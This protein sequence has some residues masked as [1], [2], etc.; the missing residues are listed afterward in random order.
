MKKV[1]IISYFFPPANF[2][3]GDRVAAWFK[4][5]QTEGYYPIIVTRCWN[6]GQSDVIGKLEH[7]EYSVERIGNG[8]IHRIPLPRDLRNKMDGPIRKLLTLRRLLGRNT[9]APVNEFKTIYD[10]CVDLLKEDPEIKTVIA[11]GRPFESF[12]IGY[13]LKKE[14][15]ITWIPDYRDEWNTHLAPANESWIWRKIHKQERTFEKVWTSNADHFLSVSPAWVTRI[16]DF[17]QKEGTV[18]MNGYDQLIEQP[19]DKTT[20]HPAL[21]LLYAGSLYAAQNIELL[22]STVNKLQK[23]GRSIQMTFI[24]TEMMPDQLERLET[25][26]K[27]MKDISFVKRLSKVEL[28]NY[29]QKADVLVMT[30]FENVDGWLPVK[31]FDYYASGKPILVCPSDHDVIDDFIAKTN[32]GVCINEAQALENQ[33]NNWCTLKEKGSAICFERNLKEGE[34][35]SREY[36]SKL[37]AKLLRSI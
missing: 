37:L 8:E 17:I 30:A 24:G 10:K 11:S 36:Q 7:N 14:F 20:S 25:L 29:Q 22:V 34:K 19:E 35:Y 9:D 13:L 1:L 12:Q 32:C 33:L 28:Q 18:I 2:V 21:H 23:E 26:T 16:G 3:G 6:E 27:G 5:L 31:M 15:D 4:H